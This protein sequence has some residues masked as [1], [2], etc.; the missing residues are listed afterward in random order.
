MWQDY[1]FPDNVLVDFYNYSEYEWL[2]GYKY[3][4]CW[5]LFNLKS[6]CSWTNT[7]LSYGA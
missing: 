6:I 2:F 5:M 4:I 3:W 1:L 7:W